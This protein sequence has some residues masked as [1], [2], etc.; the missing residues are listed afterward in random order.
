VDVG[1][2]VTCIDVEVEELEESVEVDVDN[3]EEESS[4]VVLVD[5]AGLV[6]VADAVDE[7]ESELDGVGKAAEIKGVEEGGVGGGEELAEELEVFTGGAIS[8]VV[9]E[10]ELTSIIEYL[11]VVAIDA[12]GVT[13]IITVCVF[14][15]PSIVFV[16][17]T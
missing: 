4:L 11:V 15:T 2:A 9:S 1:V 5:E 7:D 16:V 14:L 6:E 13:V 3:S 10:G 17:R 12:L 8:S